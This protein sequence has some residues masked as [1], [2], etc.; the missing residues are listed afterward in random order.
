LRQVSC[1]VAAAVVKEISDIVGF[2]YGNKTLIF[3][4]IFG[5]ASELVA[6]G[7]KRTPWRADQSLDG[8]GAL[9]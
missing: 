4:T 8:A 3:G 7:T 9:L 6:A 5:E 2:E 1:R